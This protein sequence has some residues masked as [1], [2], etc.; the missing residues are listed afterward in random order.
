MYWS[1]YSFT[2]L[3]WEDWCSSRGLVLIVMTGYYLQHVHTCQCSGFLP[4]PPEFLSLSRPTGTV[5][6]F[7][8]ISEFPRKIFKL[9]IYFTVNGHKYSSPSILRYIFHIKPHFSIFFYCE[10]ISKRILIIFAPEDADIVNDY[11]FIL[12]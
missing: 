9:N 7:S 4:E 2:G 1:K 3:G 6:R 10:V 8:G 5:V 12:A 11:L